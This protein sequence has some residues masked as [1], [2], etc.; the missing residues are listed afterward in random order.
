MS[1]ISPP[2]V[3]SPVVGFVVVWLL[4]GSFLVWM[5]RLIGLKSMKVVGM[6]YAFS[7]VPAALVASTL[8]SN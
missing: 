7:L 5:F 3:M 6:A 4:V 1:E 2:P 8:A